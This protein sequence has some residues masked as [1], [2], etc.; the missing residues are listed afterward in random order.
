VVLG[1]NLVG[2]WVF[3]G[4]SAWTGIFPP[5]AAEQMDAL[6]RHMVSEPFWR[7]LVGGGSAG[8]L[9]GL[10][11]W[12]LP[13]SGSA[14]PLIIILLTYVI[15]LCQFPHIVAGSVE[16]A[17]GVLTG[18]ASLRDYLVAFLLPTLI[19]NSAGGTIL[20]ALLNHAPL[21]AELHGRNRSG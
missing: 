1:A 19:G 11:V 15:A 17:Y 16:A 20:A 6:A 21:A 3:A 9:I 2:T 8:W 12:L 5:A 13:S 7:T 14:R 10:M 18:H 4:M